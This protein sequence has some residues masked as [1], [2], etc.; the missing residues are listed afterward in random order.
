MARIAPAAA[1]V[2]LC[3]LV[4]ASS[5][6][7]PVLPFETRVDGKVLRKSTGKLV[8]SRQGE[9]VHV[10]LGESADEVVP[11]V[12]SDRGGVGGFTLSAELP[13]GTAA[14]IRAGMMV[15]RK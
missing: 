5:A 9:T 10:L 11:I 15:R 1:G 8:L 6:S 13:E 7:P 12:L 3:C 4:G 2:P 14:K